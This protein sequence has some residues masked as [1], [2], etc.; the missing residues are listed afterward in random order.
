MAI[1]DQ[2]V[3]RELMLAVDRE[4]AWAALCDP[5]ELATWL[6]D[7]VELE[8]D[9][10]AEGV[11]RW[12]TGEERLVTVEEVQESRRISLRWREPGGEPTIVELTL[13]DVPGGTRLIVVEMPALA[14]DAAYGPI[15]LPSG[16]RWGP[17]MAMAAPA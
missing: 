7:E 1:E 5:H 15:E 13:D 9:E 3:R 14:L 16:D 2:A 11:L 8:I 6:A 12:D 10:G 4:R 17:R